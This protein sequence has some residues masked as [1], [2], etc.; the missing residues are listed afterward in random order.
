MGKRKMNKNKA[1]QGAET[2][3]KKGTSSQKAAISRKPIRSNPKLTAVPT[4]KACERLVRKISSQKSGSTP[5]PVGSKVKSKSKPKALK[6][7]TKGA[8]KSFPP[9]A[10]GSDASGLDDGSSIT[11]EALAQV[12]VTA[13]DSS[14]PVLQGESSGRNAISDREPTYNDTGYNNQLYILQYDKYKSCLQVEVYFLIWLFYILLIY[15]F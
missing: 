3:G 7:P 1:L 8:M 2:N 15:H 10:Q 14:H 9:S 6:V 4:R 11:P 13:L 12:D 5:Q